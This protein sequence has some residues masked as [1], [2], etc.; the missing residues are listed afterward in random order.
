MGAS[1]DGRHQNTN[2]CV[3]KVGIIVLYSTV[4]EAAGKYSTVL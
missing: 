4:S 2:I 3:H 1:L